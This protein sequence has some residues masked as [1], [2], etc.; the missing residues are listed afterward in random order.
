VGAVGA[1]EGRVGAGHLVGGGHV[2]RV[3]VDV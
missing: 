3:G 2:G 1:F